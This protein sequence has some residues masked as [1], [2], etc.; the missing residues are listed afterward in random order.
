MGLAPSP[1]T[2]KKDRV[3]TYNYNLSSRISVQGG[4]AYLILAHIRDLALS[5][6]GYDSTA[7]KREDEVSL[8][9]V[10]RAFSQFILSLDKSSLQTGIASEVREVHNCL[11]P[12]LASGLTCCMN[13]FSEHQ[14][15]KLYCC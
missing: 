1:S 12:W 7:S 9:P 15:L 4:N 14:N 13:Y 8:S 11:G 2:K 6:A 5:K 3:Y 10:L